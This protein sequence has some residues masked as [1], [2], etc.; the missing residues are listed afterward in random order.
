MRNIK[1]W[2]YIFLIGLMIFSSGIY[3]AESNPADDQGG[4]DDF[5]LPVI[6][7]GS[8]TGLMAGFIYMNFPY[9][10]PYAWQT[11]LLYT[12][13]EQLQCSIGMQRTFKEGDYLFLSSISFSDWPSTFWGIGGKAPDGEEE[14][15][16]LVTQQASGSFLWRLGD[17]L[18]LGP[19]LA[20]SR[21]SVED[22]TA[23]GQ[24]VQGK[25]IG[26]D[27]ADA[28]GL[29]LHLLRDRRDNARTGSAFDLKTLF[30]EESFG[31]SQTFRQLNAG[32][33]RLIPVTAS[34]VL[35]VNG[36]LTLSDGD[37]PFQL[38]PSLGSDRLMRGIE[39]D[40]YRDRHFLAIQGEY[41]FPISGRWSG[42]TFLAFGNVAD[43]A[44]DLNLEKIAGGGGV[45]YAMDASQRF[46]L[47]LDLGF[48][49]DG[50]A[51]YF[52]LQDAF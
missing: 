36:R 2:G 27:G 32:Y 22:L 15:Y 44:H 19:T 33:T 45:R 5:F 31:S 16:T 42:V 39:T 1:T 38:L 17:G 28:V 3:A 14:D 48:N 43:R 41:R 46:K 4:R 23:D 26:S 12:E 10:A 20:A 34:G 18:Y 35:A 29:G 47:R 52:G 13:K 37:V 7:Y 24:L 21:F 40:H 8:D 6:L 49:E 25:I 11:A 50:S 30:Y 9:S 51:V